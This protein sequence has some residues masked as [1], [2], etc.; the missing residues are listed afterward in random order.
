MTNEQ[1]VYV[2]TNEPASN[3]VLAFARAADGALE[4]RGSFATGG[5][6]DGVR[7]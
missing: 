6:G 3:R 7:T 4:P 1:G 2:Q 5:A